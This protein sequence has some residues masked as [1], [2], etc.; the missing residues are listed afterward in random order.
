MTVF[1]K[2]A[3]QTAISLFI[4][5]L[6]AGCDSKPASSGESA[7]QSASSAPAAAASTAPAS[8]S[9]DLSKVT[10]RV[11]Q[12]G[13]SNLELGFKEAGLS[14]TPY[15]VQYSVFQG[16]NLQLE[17]MAANNLDLGSTSEIPPIFASQ[18]ANGG[19]F[20]IIASFESTTLNQ[21]LVI[22]KGS[23]IKSVAELK[24]KKVAYV[25]ATTAHYFLVKMLQNAGL[26][27]TDIDAVPLSTSDGLSALISG[28]VD[29]LA[30][31]GNAIISAHQN[32]ATELASA[33]DILS[34]N[35][36]YEAT[37]EAINDPGK[38]A[39]IVDFLTRLDKFYA[40]T[41]SNQQKWAEITATH[42]KQPVEQ[43]LDTLKKGEEQRPSKLSAN[44]DKAIA[45]QQD[46][47]DTLTS[48]GLLKNKIEVSD[49]WSTAFEEDLKK[50][51]AAA[52]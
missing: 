31:Y 19:N 30:S 27:W 50:I 42:T 13:W 10:L 47:A 36:L 14:N 3:S 17:A 41:R 48:V 49:I 20:K 45:S 16:G 21:E 11:G 46:V 7:S 52:K 15:K 26:S 25:N 8:P 29:A 34:G 44:F 40:W 37:P 5:A 51:T 33:K 18:A 32:G 2:L 43:A 22:P 24:G 38:H 4:V 28:K 6:A 39:A 23:P 35:F 9:V 12:T 1:R